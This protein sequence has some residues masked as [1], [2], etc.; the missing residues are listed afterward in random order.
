MKPPNKLGLM[1]NK[2]I[3]RPCLRCIGSREN[4]GR[5][6]PLYKAEKKEAFSSCFV[7][8]SRLKLNLARIEKPLLERKKTKEMKSIYILRGPFN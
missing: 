7:S 5:K 2:V 3:I 6:G 1:K 8:F 4:E